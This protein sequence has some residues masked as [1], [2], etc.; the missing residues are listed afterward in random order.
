MISI[1]SQMLERRY[2][3]QLDVQAN[4]FIEQIVHG[5][6]RMDMLLKGL[7]AYAQTVNISL[8]NVQPIDAGEVLEQALLNLNASVTESGA[9][10]TY[11]SLPHVRMQEVHLLQLFQNLIGN[12]IKYR[13]EAPPH[14]EVKANREGAEWVFCVKDNGIGIP[15][16]YKDHVFRMFK[17]LHDSSKY[18]GTGIGLAICLRIVERYGG[19]LWVESE[20]GKG[21][22][23]CFTLPSVAD[24]ISRPRSRKV[25][26]TATAG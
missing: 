19:R 10:I 20:E 12:A 13:A 7:L 25:A 17:R 21:S 5:A 24:K 14:V 15:A 9:S 22:T 8:E 4:E 26:E 11:D 18:E 23:F 2:K 1:Y 6:K 3:D 16:E